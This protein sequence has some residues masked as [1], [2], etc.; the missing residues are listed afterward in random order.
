MAWSFVV[1]TVVGESEVCFNCFVVNSFVE[2]QDG[3]LSSKY[4]VPALASSTGHGGGMGVCG[5]RP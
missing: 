4:P 3:C 1:H 5:I 2:L